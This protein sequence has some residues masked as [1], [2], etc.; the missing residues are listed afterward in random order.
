MG[1]R[2]AA[3]I[4]ATGIVALFVTFASQG[5]A[6]AQ[7]FREFF[8]TLLHQRLVASMRANNEPLSEFTSDGCS[9]GMSKGWS[10][11][12]ASFPPFAKVHGGKPPWEEC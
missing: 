1:V 4:A 10:F 11:F 7:E 12:A 3:R 9:A 2:T 5:S 8:E 6:S